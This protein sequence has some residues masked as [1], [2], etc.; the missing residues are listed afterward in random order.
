MYAQN[1]GDELLVAAGVAPGRVKKN[2][3]SSWR[4]WNPSNS[5]SRRPLPGTFFV[6]SAEG[7]FAA[8][9]EEWSG[10]KVAIDVVYVYALAPV[11]QVVEARQLYFY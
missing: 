1:G 11:E 6:C 3:R 10:G 2:P 8:A 5:L 9:V 7:I 4:I